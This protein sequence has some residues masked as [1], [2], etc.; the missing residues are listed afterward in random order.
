MISIVT[1]AFNESRNLPLLY[2]R[3]CATMESLGL[4]WEWIVVDDH[5]SDDT[6]AVINRLAERD[7]RVRGVRGARY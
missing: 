7:R 1:P 2:E 6:F 5:S 4:D 3:I